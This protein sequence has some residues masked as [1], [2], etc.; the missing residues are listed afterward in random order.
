MTHGRP[1]IG[2]TQRTTDVTASG[3]TR[4]RSTSRRR[5]PWTARWPAS[6]WRS[7]AACVRR[8][9]E[10]AAARPPIARPRAAASD[11]AAAAPAA[12][13]RAARRSRSASSRSSRSTSTTRMVDAAKDVGRGP[14]GR[15]ARLRP[16]QERHRRRGRDRADRV[17]DHPGREGASRSRRPARTSRPR[18][19]RRVDAGI[20]V[21]LVDNDIP[22]WTGKSSVVATDN[23]AGGKLAG[24]V[25]PGH[26]PAGDKIAVLKGVLGEPVARGP[27]HRD[28]STRSGPP[29]EGRRQGSPT[30][31][32][33][34]QGRSTR[35]RTC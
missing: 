14:P 21:V 34:D 23:L 4:G 11:T 32:R 20:K 27:R 12:S 19:T 7:V 29:A 1:R 13:R 10:R 31:L 33:P 28:D 30:G 35:P 18:S 9:L 15:R 3:P 16:G 17:D 5:Q 26:L 22:D 2:R 8:R 24:D 6:S 25:A